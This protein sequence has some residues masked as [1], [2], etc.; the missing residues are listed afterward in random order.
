MDKLVE[1]GFIDKM[2]YVIPLT[3]ILFI[4]SFLAYSLL[5]GILASMTTNMEDYQQ[6]QAPIM[7]ICL[8]GYYLSILAALFEG[9][10]FIKIASYIPFISALLA[11]PLLVIGQI[12]ILDI[13]ISIIVL[14]IFNYLLLKYGLKVYKVGILN[15]S[16]SKLWTKIFK[17]ARE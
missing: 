9:S 8:L 14:I 11:P 10:I 17:A 2:L 1:S 13:S 15:Y 4:L 7:I 6:I 16:T 12:G 3:I 5:A